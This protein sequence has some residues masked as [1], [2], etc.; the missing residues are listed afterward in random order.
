MYIFIV[1]S[2]GALAT[3]E[4]LWM[5]TTLRHEAPSWLVIDGLSWNEAIE[6]VIPS[7][8]SLAH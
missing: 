7:I 2:K 4:I 1:I 5:T 3:R 8:I 6:A